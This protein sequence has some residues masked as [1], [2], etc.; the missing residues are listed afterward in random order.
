ME[1]RRLPQSL[2]EAAAAEQKARLARREQGV[3]SKKKQ[4][5]KTSFNESDGD[6]DDFAEDIDGKLHCH[7]LLPFLP[8]SIDDH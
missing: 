7:K 3:P 4:G 2:L 8:E 1:E 5:K 6:D